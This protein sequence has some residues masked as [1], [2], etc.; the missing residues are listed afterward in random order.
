[1][2]ENHIVVVIVPYDVAALAQ[3][4]ARLIHRLLRL[5]DVAVGVGPVEVRRFVG[6]D[7]D[8]LIAVIDFPHGEEHSRVQI[9]ADGGQIRPAAHAAAVRRGCGRDRPAVLSVAL[10]LDLDGVLHALRGHVPVLAGRQTAFDFVAAVIPYKLRNLGEHV[11]VG[12]PVRAAVADPPDGIRQKGKRLP[13]QHLKTVFA[14]GAALVAEQHR[15]VLRRTLRDGDGLFRL[16]VLEIESALGVFKV[17]GRDRRDA[18][19]AVVDAQA[20]L[21][22]GTRDGEDVVL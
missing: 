10:V 2:R 18:A 19:C 11:G 12:E 8:V 22:R 14:E 7:L 5:V 1:M 21:T 17:D 16:A 13:V 15:D 20:S 6:Q 4:P 3:L 9:V